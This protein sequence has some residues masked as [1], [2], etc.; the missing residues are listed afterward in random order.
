MQGD[1]RVGTDDDGVYK[2]STKNVDTSGN[3]GAETIKTIERDTMP[4]DK[5]SV[6]PVPDE[7]NFSVVL[8]VTGEAG[9]TPGQ[10]K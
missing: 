1:R 3:L 5:P 2:I 9:R 6:T 4:P 10:V 8:K 7:D